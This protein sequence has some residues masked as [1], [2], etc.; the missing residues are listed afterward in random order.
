MDTIELIIEAYTRVADGMRRIDLEDEGVKV[1]AY[2]AG[3]IIRI[4]INEKQTT[5]ETEG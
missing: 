2:R 3:T 5:T 1:K 4:D